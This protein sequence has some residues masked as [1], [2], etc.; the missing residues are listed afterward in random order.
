MAGLGFG[1]AGTIPH[2]DGQRTYHY[3]ATP[4]GLLALRTIFGERAMLDLTMREYY[5]SG[6]G[7]DDKR[8]S[9][10]IF[11]GDAGITFRIY[12]NHA[13]GLEFLSFNRRAHY[14]RVPSQYQTEGQFSLVYTYLGGS[15]FGAVDWR[16]NGEP[17]LK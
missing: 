8:G 17:L 2:P 3:G 1:G 15:R 4:Q 6:T 12:G 11:R 10:Q 13:I 14:V 7:S 16:P 9:E 5:V